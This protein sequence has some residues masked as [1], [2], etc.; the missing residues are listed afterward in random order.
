VDR[1]G[2]VLQ[3]A[4]RGVTQEATLAVREVS[5][6]PN[7]LLA[8]LPPTLQQRRLARLVIAALVIAC[9]IAAP[10]AAIPLPHVDAFIPCVKITIFV[11]DSIDRGEYCEAAGASAEIVVAPNRLFTGHG[12]QAQI[13]SR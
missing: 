5:N 6:E 8:T 9:G 7:L 11:N 12:G 3:H 1:I 10:F 4:A 2:R 13:T